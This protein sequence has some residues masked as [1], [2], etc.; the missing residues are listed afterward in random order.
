ML[1]NSRSLQWP[2]LGR[3]GRVGATSASAWGGGRHQAAWRRGRGGP[4]S[5]SAGRPLTAAVMAV[6]ARR[7]VRTLGSRWRLVDRCY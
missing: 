6:Y 4:A 2:R 5:S 3:V 1:R 7:L